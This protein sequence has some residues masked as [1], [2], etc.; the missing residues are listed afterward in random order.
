Q[1]VHLQLYTLDGGLA[2]VGR[3][4]GEGVGNT[5]AGGIDADRTGHLNVGVV[6]VEQRQVGID[7]AVSERRLG[8]DLPSVDGFRVEAHEFED[9]VFAD[10]AIAVKIRCGGGQSAGVEAAALEALAPGDIEVVF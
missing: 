1:G 2:G 5:V 4:P 8:A 7:P 3:D 6:A 10:H 9:L